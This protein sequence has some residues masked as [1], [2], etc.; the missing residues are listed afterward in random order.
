M[1]VRQVFYQATVR[2]LVEKAE[3]GYG[4]VWQARSHGHAPGA[5]SF[6][7]DWLA[8]NTP[9]ATQ[10]RRTFRQARR[11]R[12]RSVAQLGGP[13]APARAEPRARRQTSRFLAVPNETPNPR[14][15]DSLPASFRHGPFVSERAL[16]PGL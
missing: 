12:T 11:L 16:G 3:S 8:D 1:T 2:G 9:L 15:P 14:Q 5:P 10:S 13:V 4:K 7:Y 6:P